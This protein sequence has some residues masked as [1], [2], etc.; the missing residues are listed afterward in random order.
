MPNYEYQSNCGKTLLKFF[1]MKDNRPDSIEENGIVYHKIFSIP[2]VIVDGRKP[3]TIGDLA[4]KNTSKM[5]KEKGS[6]ST[7]SN[8]LPWWRQHKLNK[9]LNKLTKTQKEKYIKTGKL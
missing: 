8:D 6:K 5:I 1:H 2:N 7:T 4:A 9:K 3:K